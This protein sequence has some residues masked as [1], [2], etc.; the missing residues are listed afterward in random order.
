MDLRRI[1]KKLREAE[2][3]LFHL[4]QREQQ[5][6][7]IAEELDFVLS[8]FLSAARAVDYRLRHE[9][10]DGYRAWRKEWD[11]KV[12]PSDRS[13]LKFIDD[14]RSFEVHESGSRRTEKHSAWAVRAEEGTVVG[15][16]QLPGPMP[17]AIAKPEFFY[18]V[19][20]DGRE[21][22]ASDVCERYVELAKAM[23]QAFRTEMTSAMPS[24]TGQT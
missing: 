23:V 18:S 19:T 5:P 16:V 3:F 24:A 12:A 15:F 21:E 13:L 4:K 11:E 7:G 8:A 9:Q 22:R 1:E 2:F 6:L 10:G 20:V 17:G 14:D